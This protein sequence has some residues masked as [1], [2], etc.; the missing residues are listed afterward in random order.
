[1]LLSRI[2]AHSPQL[3][4]TVVKRSDGTDLGFRSHGQVTGVMARVITELGVHVPQT[5]TTTIRYRE[6]VLTWGTGL[7]SLGV[8]WGSLWMW[9][10]HLKVQVSTSLLEKGKKSGSWFPSWAPD[11]SADTHIQRTIDKPHPKGHVSAVICG[12]STSGC[13]F[14]PEN[15]VYDFL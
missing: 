15:G 8:P 7:G 6:V 9:S 1:M 13:D 5:H 4:Y 3:S 2:L 10:C 12:F 11:K 14:G